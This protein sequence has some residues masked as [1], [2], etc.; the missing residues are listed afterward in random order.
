M[1]SSCPANSI[2]VQGQGLGVLRRAGKGTVGS[3]D[4]AKLTRTGSMSAVAVTTAKTTG[5][6]AIFL[7]QWAM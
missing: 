5:G 2:P 3:A 4:Q 7:G 1:S 6:V